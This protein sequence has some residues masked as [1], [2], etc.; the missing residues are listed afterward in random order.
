MTNR[1]ARYHDVIRRKTSSLR[2]PHY[3]SAVLIRLP[4]K[5]VIRYD[6]TAALWEKLRTVPAFPFNS[7]PVYAVF[8]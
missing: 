7:T 1:T 6:Q 4:V 2:C 5:N 8:R 3:R